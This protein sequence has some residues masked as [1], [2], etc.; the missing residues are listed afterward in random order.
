VILSVA[1]FANYARTV[2]KLI[3]GAAHVR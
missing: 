1:T 2:P 3:A